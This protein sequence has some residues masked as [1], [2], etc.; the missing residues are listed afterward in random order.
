MATAEQEGDE[1]GEND[2]PPSVTRCS[3]EDDHAGGESS[4]A[5]SQKLDA[6]DNNS[7]SPSPPSTLR[8]SEKGMQQSTT[9]FAF[10]AYFVA[11]VSLVAL[12]LV[13]T[14]SVLPLDAK[15]EYFAM[16]DEVR[17]HL[18][19]GKLLKIEL[20][21]DQEPLKVFVREEGSLGGESV[22]L[23]HG[24]GASSFLYRRVIPRLVSLGLHV[25]A[26]DFPGAGLSEKPVQGGLLA[27]FRAIYEEI[28]ETGLF[29]RFEQLFE[30][31]SLPDYGPVGMTGLNY[32]AEDL[33]DSLAQV[34]N[35]LA[36]TAV[37]VVFHDT[38]VQ[39]GL[40][41]VV[42][43]PSRVRSITLIDALP[44]SP[45]FPMTVLGIP[46]VGFMFTRFSFLHWMLLRVCCVPGLSQAEAENH[47]FLLRNNDGQKAALETWREMNATF[48]LAAMMEGLGHVPVQVVWSSSSGKHW[49][50]IGEKLAYQ[51]P[52]ASYISHRGS[53]WPQEDAAPEIAED[54]H[55][56][57]SSFPPTEHL[58]FHEPTPLHVQEM[59]EQMARGD[60][61][62]HHDHDHGHA[63]HHYGHGHDSHGHGQWDH[64]HDH[65]EA[66][67]DGMGLGGWVF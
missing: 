52:G 45:S 25:I 53:R 31:G 17:Q 33:G 15:A 54:I 60:G 64:M 24:L 48:D 63:S 28:C 58:S 47:A 13:F 43:N 19:S 8:V 18:T 20:G 14:S 44:N 42:R 30:T 57:V 1:V 10:W 2:R 35:L 56:F 16:P 55:H 26:M 67:P 39:A 3:T 9:V 41:C 12:V 23:V 46:V 11:V 7:G 59:L 65:E 21:A 66:Y 6:G 61:G 4:M 36:P 62:N 29:W 49:Q 51:L 50:K 27:K 40:A 22:V 37:H 38:G 32:H 5:A 34:L